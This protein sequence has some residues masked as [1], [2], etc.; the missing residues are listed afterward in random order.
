VF[1]ILPINSVATRTLQAA[2]ALGREQEIGSLETGKK[3]PTLR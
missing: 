1:S 2:K 3:M